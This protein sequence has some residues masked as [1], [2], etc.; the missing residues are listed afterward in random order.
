LAACAVISAVVVI[1]VPDTPSLGMRV[2]PVQRKV[3]AAFRCQWERAMEMLFAYLFS[4]Q[5]QMIAPLPA[6][7]MVILVVARYA[8]RR[9]HARAR[10]DERLPGSASRF[11]RHV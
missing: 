2:C 5:I 6:A 1:P 7:V 3:R 10:I 11:V 4:V 8:A 9:A